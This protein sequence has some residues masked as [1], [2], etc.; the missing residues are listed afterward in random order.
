VSSGRALAVTLAVVAVVGPCLLPA[1]AA[2]G[3]L[4]VLMFPQEFGL[5]PG[6]TV[7]VRIEVYRWGVPYDPANLTLFEARGSWYEEVNTTNVSVGRWRA[8]VL[9]NASWPV[10]AAFE[11]FGWVQDDD[12]SFGG[13]QVG[14]TV[15]PR[16]PIW[17]VRGRIVAE[18]TSSPRPGPGD[19]V[20]VEARTYEDGLLSGAL[21]PSV[22]LS[23]FEGGVG[24]DEELNGTKVSE[25]VWRYSFAV[26]SDLVATRRYAV[27]ASIP[28]ARAAYPQ[29]L[30][31]IAHPFEFAISA[32]VTAS[33]IVANVWMWD[34]RGPAEG[35][36]VLLVPTAA[37]VGAQSSYADDE[38]HAVA[39]AEFSPVPVSRTL[40]VAVRMAYQGMTAEEQLRVTPTSEPGPGGGFLAV[41]GGC[42][43]VFTEDVTGWHRGELALLPM[44]F[45]DGASEADNANIGF[46]YWRSGDTG[47]VHLH[48]LS[49]NATGGYVLE[50]HIPDDW[51]QDDY[52]QVRFVCP[53]GDP[54]S[55]GTYFEPFEREPSGAVALTATDGAG[56]RIEVTAAR[57]PESGAAFGPGWVGVAPGSSIDAGRRGALG[58]TLVC[59]F[60]DTAED[61]TSCAV[62]IPPNL[63]EG[64]Y[65]AFGY[66][67]SAGFTA[68]L[69]REGYVTNATLVTWS[70][71][72][73][74][75]E[76]QVPGTG[77]AP[78]PWLE[79]TVGAAVALAAVGALVALRR[80]RGG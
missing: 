42:S 75:P 24:N 30:D 34:G 74:P 47:A 73:P 46:W 22:H 12:G 55:T 11:L 20:V 3:G 37:N 57:T 14:Y 64:S 44:Q 60:P 16:F 68:N 15:G 63:P 77:G 79:A 41:S 62:D 6:E 71:E 52:L 80:R 32:N 49:L 43:G 54:G 4:L 17:E 51:R 21:D 59:G 23:T 72:A 70:R 13:E 38:G 48:N 50:Y 45:F 8:D 40:V 29:S 35:A 66:T 58:G 39:I 5:G 28:D 65:V 69:S 76:E 19:T 7:E 2:D 53:N 1:A 10:G 33:A 18:G 78:F 56:E 67:T 25:G 27:T 26:P 36:G 31:V 9:I 61:N